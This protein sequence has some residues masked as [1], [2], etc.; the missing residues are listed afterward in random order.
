MNTIS[1]DDDECLDDL[2]LFSSLETS[3]ADSLRS[4]TSS[5]I[6]FLVLNRHATLWILESRFGIVRSQLHPSREGPPATSPR[7]P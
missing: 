4:E 3:S 5:E 1:L 2:E 7:V 6:S